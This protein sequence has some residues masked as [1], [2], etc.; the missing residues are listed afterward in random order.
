MMVSYEGE[1]DYI[2]ISYCHRD[3]KQIMPVVQR[4]V[5]DGYRVWYDEGINPGNEWPE[6][7][8]THLKDCAL[9]IAF[10]SGDY[11][12]S[13]NCKREIDYAVSQRKNFIAVYLQEV[14]M[15]PGMEMQLSSVQALNKYQMDEEQFFTCLYRSDLISSSRDVTDAD[16]QEQP[17]ESPYVKT[18]AD[19][20]KNNRKLPHKRSGKSSE[21]KKKLSNV[22]ILAIIAAVMGA[23]FVIRLV[24]A[25]LN[26]VNIAGTDISRSETHL[27]F[28]NA[29]FSSDDLK[30]MSVLKDLNTL[31]LTNCTFTGEAKELNNLPD[32]LTTLNLDGCNGISDYGFISSLP[33]LKTL[34]IENSDIT[35]A[36]LETIDFAALVELANLQLNGN[37]KISSIEPIAL[38]EALTVLEISDTMVSDLTPLS[39][40]RGVTTLEADDTLISDLTPL[41]SDSELKRLSINHCKVTSLTPLRDMDKLE[42]L[43]ADRNE[44]DDLD[45]LQDKGQ[46]VTLSVAQNQIKDLD[47]LE[48]AFRLEDLIAYG[49]HLT[50]ADGLSSCIAL[51]NVDLHDNE[52]SDV[53]ALS[54]S[55]GSLYRFDIRGNSLTDLS[56]LSGMPSLTCFYADDNQISDISFLAESL[57]LE[58]ISAE[59]NRIGSFDPLTGLA[60]LQSIYLGNNEISGEISLEKM[61][62]LRN[63]RLQH[64]K[65]NSISY[66][67]EERETVMGMPVHISMLAAYDNPLYEI[68]D[69]Y[70]SE[71]DKTGNKINEGYISFPSEEEA[72]SAG[73]AFDP[74]TMTDCFHE[75]YLDDC[76]LD[77][78]LK[79]EEVNSRIEYTDTGSMDLKMKEK[80][81]TGFSIE[82]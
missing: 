8:A 82:I 19:P 6:I 52:L 67:S 76:P 5:N 17:S 26:E 7:V 51:R 60:K 44:I 80:G 41:A 55:R 27:S 39:G 72:S 65:I 64:N 58:T 11:L 53:N 73:Y 35:D 24:S 69:I 23:V 50:S 20:V 10:I 47:E 62:F 77:Q 22:K 34:T 31:K 28:N 29:S 30:N 68:K 15:T 57:L 9:F 81:S 32:N 40:M 43:S 71:D 4:L 18:P 25:N 56:E 13:F 1:K 45:G 3:E 21:R 33:G 37:S 2:F 36:D 63:V 61:P 49:N 48:S 70:T 46:L 16:A 12:D 54:K 42:V 79:L 74:Y 59:N 75:L 66:S 14:K 78:R 38:V